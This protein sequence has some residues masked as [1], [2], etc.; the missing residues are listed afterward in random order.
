VD[1]LADKAEP[2][3][4]FLRVRQVRVVRD[5]GDAGRA[6]VTVVRRDTLAGREPIPWPNVSA[7]RLS[8][9]EPIPLGVD[10]AGQWVRVSVPE[11]HIIVAG[12]PGGGKSVLV[13]MLVATAAMDPSVRLTLFDGKLV[14]LAVWRNCAERVVGTDLADAIDA[15]RELRAEMDRRYELLLARG[16]RK[17]EP[18]DRVPLHLVALDLCRY[19]DYAEHDGALSFSGVAAQTIRTTATAH[20][21]A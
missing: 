2:V 20:R 14:E 15:L 5:G 1:A 3:A 10:E 13:S 6:A 16:L 17:F 19:R 9:A 12:E 8:L 4:A 21:S 11:R 7:A 18:S